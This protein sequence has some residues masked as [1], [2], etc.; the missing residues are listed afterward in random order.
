[1]ENNKMSNL[2]RVRIM[3]GI[4]QADLARA[5]EIKPQ[6]LQ[7]YEAGQQIGPKMLPV[8][9]SALNVSQ[10]Y[11]RGMADHLSVYDWNAGVSTPCEIVSEV[12]IEGYGIHYIVD[13]PVIG[14]MVVL[15]S[16]GVQFT[17][18]DWQGM[19][20]FTVD[21]IADVTWVDNHGNPAVML[22]GL[23]RAL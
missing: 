7:N 10:A 14:F 20:P 15:Q 9:A 23:P 3:R 12:E 8:F 4:N 11:L 13:H 18:W 16:A 19:C 21:E 17:P 6:Q 1:M 2:K 5:L 22:D